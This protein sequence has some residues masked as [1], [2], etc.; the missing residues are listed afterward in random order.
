MHPRWKWTLVIAVAAAEK[1]DSAC[2]LAVVAPP[3]SDKFEFFR[4]RLGKTEGSLD[5]L[6]AAREELDVRDAFGQQ[7]ADQIEKTRTG[8]GRE[9]AE[10]DTTELL[11]ETFD[12][13]RMRVADTADCDTGDEIQILIPID[14]DD[15]SAFRVVHNDL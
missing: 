2:G 10:G 14:V 6:R 5:G 8:L 4:Y 1:A 13:V 3:K 12:V 9:A 15:G 7:L 11:V